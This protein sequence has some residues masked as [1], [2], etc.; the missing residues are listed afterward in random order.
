LG[1]NP[2][3]PVYERFRLGGT[4]L[5]S[6]RGYDDREI[7]P[8]GNASDVGGRF[9][10]IGSLEYRVPVIKNQAFVRSFF[11]AGDTWNSVRAARPAFLK[12]GAGVGFMIQIPMVGQIGLDVAY[13]FDRG[14]LYGGP[15]WKTHFQFG[16]SGF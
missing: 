10:M 15:G 1:S 3:I 13:G 5:E 2:Y 16:M 14:K 8:E 4:T 11:D 6:V 9:M 12:S 7:V